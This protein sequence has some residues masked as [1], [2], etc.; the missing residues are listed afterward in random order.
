MNRNIHIEAFRE[1]NDPDINRELNELNH[2]NDIEISNRIIEIQNKL[3]C[4]IIKENPYT[5]PLYWSGPSEYNSTYIY[6]SEAISDYT[7]FDAPESM[8]A[9]YIIASIHPKPIMCQWDNTCFFSASI[10]LLASIRPLVAYCRRLSEFLLNYR[11]RDNPLYAG[12]LE[13][14]KSKYPAIGEFDSYLSSMPPKEIDAYIKCVKLITALITDPSNLYNSDINVIKNIMEYHGLTYGEQY[15]ARLFITSILDDLNL[16]ILEEFNG[17]RLDNLQVTADLYFI[18]RSGPRPSYLLYF[19]VFHIPREMIYDYLVAGIV[20]HKSCPT[21]INIDFSNWSDC[22][23]RGISFRLGRDHRWAI[24][25]NN[26]LACY[27]TEYD[28][29][30]WIYTIINGK[31]YYPDIYSKLPNWL[32]D[33]GNVSECAYRE[34]CLKYN[35][36]SIYYSNGW[37]YTPMFTLRAIG[38]DKRYTIQFNRLG[39]NSTGHYVTY[40]P[41]H[42]LLFDTG[43]EFSNGEWKKFKRV[44]TFPPND[45]DIYRARAILYY[46]VKEVTNYLQQ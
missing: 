19:P 24:Y 8:Y 17:I 34:M 20:Y 28:N 39:E 42:Q 21:S 15:D 31:I 12:Y 41:K 36:T 18:K 1:R 45:G 29:R 14:I 10:E 7:E 38:G 40:F 35:T 37:Y 4:R 11:Y 23:S 46:D 32:S 30:F 22:N 33:D 13:F 26:D 43:N 16:R 3:N 44:K 9:T 5:K 27:F 6:P 2:M 25:V